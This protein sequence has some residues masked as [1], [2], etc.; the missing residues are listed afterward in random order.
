MIAEYMTALF[1]YFSNRMGALKANAKEDAYSFMKTG[2][3]KEL[4]VPIPDIDTQRQYV[5]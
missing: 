5:D 3:L 2:V 1:T 4:V